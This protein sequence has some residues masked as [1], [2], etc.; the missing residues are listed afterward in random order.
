M[1]NLL[2]IKEGFTGYSGEVKISLIKNGVKYK[3]VETHNRGTEEFFLYILNCICGQPRYEYRPAYLYLY[4]Y[5]SESGTET[6]LVNFGILYEG[7]TY[8]NSGTDIEKGAYANLTYRF[9]IPY[10]IIKGRDI[11]RL[12]L[13]S[14]SKQGNEYLTYAEL[15]LGQKITIDTDTNL[16]VEW[17]LKIENKEV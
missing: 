8:I 7:D 14:L 16:E 17:T 4:N 11:N 2:S 1:K 5:N 3:V 12:R 10:T 15:D 9:M 13:K 6:Q